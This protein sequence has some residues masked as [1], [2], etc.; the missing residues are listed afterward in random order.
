[1]L[2]SASIVP[3]SGWD[4]VSCK[5]LISYIVDVSR[6]ALVLDIE[7]CAHVVVLQQVFVVVKIV[8]GAHTAWIGACSAGN[9]PF[10]VVLAASRRGP[11]SIRRD[12]PVVEVVEVVEHEVHVFLFLA[13]Q[14][15]DDSL[16]L[17]HLN[18]DMGVCLPGN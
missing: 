4:S 17:V 11:P 16:V 6:S 13:L 18:S 12:S 10:A 2:I 14:V 1:M 8:L 5:V 9:W 7:R 3:L 15:V